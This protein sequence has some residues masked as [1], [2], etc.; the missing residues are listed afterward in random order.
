MDGTP[1]TVNPDIR[2]IFIPRGGLLRQA[3]HI[4]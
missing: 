1:A 2:F 4:L 3:R